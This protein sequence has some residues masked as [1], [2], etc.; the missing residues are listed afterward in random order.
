M[1]GAAPFPLNP[2]L[3]IGSHAWLSACAVGAFAMHEVAWTNGCGEDDDV[4]DACLQLDADADP[5]RPPHLG[6]LATGM[7][8][9]RPGDGLYRDRLVAPPGRALCVPNPLGRLRQLV[10]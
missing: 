4:F 5:T 7:R 2:T 6:L 8:F 10:I 9:G 1:I 3:T